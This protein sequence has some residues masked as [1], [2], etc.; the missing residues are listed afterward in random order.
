[1]SVKQDGVAPRTAADVERKYQK[2][3]SEM[4]GI[5]DETRKDVDAVE[6]SL[7]KEITEQATTLTRT[8]E[9][10][11]IKATESVRSDLDGSVEDLNDSVSELSRQVEMKID[12]SAVNIVVQEEVAKGVTKVQTQTGY[13]FDDEGLKISK[14]GEEMEN[15]LDNTG[16]YVKQ[17][18]HVILQANNKG[19]EASDITVR[20]Y[21]VVGQNSRF[22]DYD[23]RT[24]C[25]WI[26]G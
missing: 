17:N 7:R 23:G 2:K 18:G 22:E 12:A 9:D 26:G 15:K 1:M 19:V 14:S 25:F 20:N 10:V 6:S 16:M 21:L 13:T 5:I 8:T 24:G 4:L 11:V 3:F